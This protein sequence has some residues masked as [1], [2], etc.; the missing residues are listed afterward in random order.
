MA[1]LKAVPVI[2][3]NLIAIYKVL[4]RNGKYQAVQT[5][6]TQ[7]VGHQFVAVQILG[8]SE[9]Q[10]VEYNL[11]STWIRDCYE[12]FTFHLPVVFIIRYRL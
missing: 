4:V 5:L 2:G 1:S 9:I 7:A 10:P 3:E 6:M 11:P 8:I 12:R